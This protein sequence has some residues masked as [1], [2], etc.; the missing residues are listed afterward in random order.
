MWAFINERF[1]I[2]ERET[3]IRRDFT[4]KGQIK[5]YFSATRGKILTHSQYDSNM[6]T[7]HIEA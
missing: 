1:Q 5:G 7:G 3:G 6:N 4:Q 2:E